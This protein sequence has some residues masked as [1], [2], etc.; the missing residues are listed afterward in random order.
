[1]LKPFVIQYAAAVQAVVKM[2]QSASCS[3]VE[4]KQL[5]AG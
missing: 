2:V 4:H 5:A 3:V 1:M